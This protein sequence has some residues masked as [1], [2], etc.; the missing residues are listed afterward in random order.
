MSEENKE[1]ELTDEQYK[2][3]L[4]PFGARLDALLRGAVGGIVIN[5]L[6]ENRVREEII[7]VCQLLGKRMLGSRNLTVWSEASIRFYKLFFNASDDREAQ[8]VKPQIGPSKEWFEFL[9]AC[10]QPNASKVFEPALIVLADC[11]HLLRDPRN[12]RLLRETVEAGRKLRKTFVLVGQYGEL[13]PELQPDFKALDFELPRAQDIE[14]IVTKVLARYKKT[15]GFEKV[16]IDDSA[17]K[18]FARACL[19]ITEQEV[20]ASIPIA[21]AK[22]SAFDARAVDEALAEKTRIV[23]RSKAL[24]VIQPNVNLSSVGGLSNVKRW[25]DDVTPILHNPAQA[26]EYGLKL[27]TGV[28]LLGISGTGKSLTSEALASH[29]KLPLL[30]FD[31]G[32]AFGSLL[33]ESEANLRRVIEVAQAAA[34]CVLRIDEIEKA[35]GGDSNDGGTSQRVLAT[36]LT[37]LENKPEDVIV[38][39]TANDLRALA[40]RPEL[41][42]RFSNTFFVDLPG[43]DSRCEIL[44][45]HLGTR[46]KLKDLLVEEVASLTKGYSG[47]ELR[48]VVQTALGLSFKLKLEHPT[49]PQFTHAVRLITPTSRSLKESIDDLRRWC[50][51]GKAVSADTTNDNAEPLE[52]GPSG[53]LAQL[54]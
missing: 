32:S 26:R 28:L 54:S 48:N 16:V 41:V 37:W 52:H 49:S 21:I 10:L 50:A 2:A 11:A 31:V 47:R 22:H 42:Q 23:G 8:V 5:T 27:P 45:I 40:R 53:D 44:R 13:P 43:F 9:P 7:P 33:G 6:E 4:S 24:K 15:P 30:H 3:Q 20:K 25:I 29:W 12:V 46:H 19:G 36:L 1:P 39:A 38:V 17:V 18:P 14:D 51:E 34:P 35:L